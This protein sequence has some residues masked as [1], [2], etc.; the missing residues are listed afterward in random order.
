MKT[1]KT[2]GMYDTFSRT[3]KPVRASHYCAGCGHGILHKLITEA[4]VD[5]GLQDRA[6]M[7]NPIGCAVFGY[8]YWDV[9]NIGAAHGR[10]QAIATAV[11][12]VR[13]DAITLAYQGDGDLG[14]IGFN[15]TFQAASRGERMAV[16]FVNNAIYGMT[17]GQMAPTSLIAQKTATSPTGRDAFNDGQPLHV[18]E[19]LSQLKAPVYIARCS[20]ADTKRIMQ[21]RAAV[22]KALEI[23]RDNKG[24][25]FVEFLSPCPT[26]FGMDSLT[27][28]N[29]VATEMEKEYPLGVFRDAI[30]ETA[31]RER[32]PPR[33]KSVAELF[34]GADDAVADAKEDPGVKELR[35]KLSGFGGQGIL[36][37]GVCVAEAGRYAGRFTTWLPS[38]GP[39]QRGGSASC[40]VVVAGRAVGSPSVD[41][42]DVLVCMNQ[43][44]YERFA[45]TVAAG[46]VLVVDAT[47]PLDSGKPPA[48]VRVVS[49]PA[50]QLAT[51]HG[52]PKAANTVM[53]GALSAL[54]ALGLP[55]ETLLKALADSFWKK[56]S[57]VP[58]NEAV[59][60][61]A[62]AWCTENIK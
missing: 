28:A 4:L 58:K 22:R 26:N 5:L 10:A 53:L 45:P 46:G 49:V 7:V 23:Q 47:V 31:P 3:G 34:A 27:S 38:Y 24:Y 42:P 13:P 15:N 37:L 50:I 36:S 1:L 6:V 2:V 21:S 44:S 57:L 25:A 12:R 59:F 43:P 60:T 29:F 16:F 52:V 54:G 48:G 55:R 62:E 17:G 19:V 20:L 32:K 18:C 9:G 56:P 30:A 8:Y 11:S 33:C 61:A 39:E 51:D 14:A 35:V 41:T 40:S